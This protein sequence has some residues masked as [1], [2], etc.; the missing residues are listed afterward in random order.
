MSKMSIIASAIVIQNMLQTVHHFGQCISEP[1]L[2]QERWSLLW[3]VIQNPVL[4]EAHFI[5]Q[6]SDEKV[7]GA[8]PAAIHRMPFGENC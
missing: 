5:H 7:C 4:H 8:D 2:L 6:H 1:C 3:I